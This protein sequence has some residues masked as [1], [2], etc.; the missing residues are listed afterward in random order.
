MFLY[1]LLLQKKPNT[2]WKKAVAS[3]ESS[4][5]IF[6]ERAAGN[7]KG[8]VLEYGRTLPQEVPIFKVLQ[9]RGDLKEGRHV[10]EEGDETSPSTKKRGL[11]SI[12][13]K[14]SIRKKNE[15]LY[16]KKTGNYLPREELS[17]H[18]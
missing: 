16:Q 1:P 8:S 4:Y 10:F 2:A 15:S 5:S 12:S 13:K 3:G 11:Y 7:K 14:E 18:K 6:I 17:Y 9:R